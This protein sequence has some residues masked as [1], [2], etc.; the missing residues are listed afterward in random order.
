MDYEL[1]LDTVTESVKRH[2]D[3]IDERL[4]AECTELERSLLSF[5]RLAYVNVLDEISTF[6]TVMIKMAFSDKTKEFKQLVGE[7]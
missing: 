5:Q 4:E 2:R 3:L 1:I 7:K 6:K